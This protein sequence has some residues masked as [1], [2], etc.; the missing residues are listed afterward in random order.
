MLDYL[1]WIYLAN[2]ALLITHEIDSAYWKEW[3]LFRLPGGPGGFLLIH[4]PLVFAVLWGAAELRAGTAAGLW[5]SLLV[6][7]GG[8]F[9][10]CIHMLF[11]ARGREEFRAPVSIAI[12]VGTL[13]LSLA[14]TALS[15]LLL[16]A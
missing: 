11:I 10:F 2:A 15:V 16:A 7:L 12:L 13:A 4:I 6:G 14:Q 3:E 5:I 8:V 1:F 9:A